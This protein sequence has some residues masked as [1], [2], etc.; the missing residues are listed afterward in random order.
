[1]HQAVLLDLL[2][3]CCP[4]CSGPSLLGESA[5]DSHV[6]VLCG[7]RYR[8][9]GARFLS[10]CGSVRVLDCD[11]TAE[12]LYRFKL[13]VDELDLSSVTVLTTPQGRTQ[14]RRYQERLFTAVYTFDYKVRSSDKVACPSCT[15]SAHTDSPGGGVQEDVSRFVQQLPALNG[16][17][18]VLRSTLIPGGFDQTH[19]CRDRVETFM[20]HAV[21]A[22]QQNLGPLKLHLLPVAEQRS[23]LQSV[24]ASVVFK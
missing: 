20:L 15:G 18:R 12:S 24:T 2:H 3:G 14:L 22:L 10:S 7:K 5:S 13:T 9:E 1:M 4:S 8:A 16:E 21:G 17:V 6:F 23:E 11:S 19:L